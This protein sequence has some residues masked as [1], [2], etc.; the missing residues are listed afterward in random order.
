MVRGKIAQL[1]YRSMTRYS[2]SPLKHAGDRRA[3]GLIRKP[4]AVRKA[5]VKSA[6]FY[7]WCSRRVSG[8]AFLTIYRVFP[9]NGS[10]TVSCSQHLWS[11]FSL[12]IAV[13]IAS[14][15]FRLLSNVLV[16]MLNVTNPIL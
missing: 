3:S 15:G 5:E 10:G 13:S 16:K 7:R 12:A 14:D 9:G 4:V 11:P 8:A 1:S 6:A 2:Q